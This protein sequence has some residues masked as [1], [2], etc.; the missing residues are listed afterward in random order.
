MVLLLLAHF[1]EKEE[2]LFHFVEKT[3]LAEKVQMENVSLTPC[4]IVCG[5]VS[6]LNQTCKLSLLQCKL[7]LLAYLLSCYLAAHFKTL[8]N[9]LPDK[10]C[11]Q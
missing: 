9:I 10:F 8:A 4:L 7:V 5:T 1:D 2:Q 3:S 6:K 11:Q